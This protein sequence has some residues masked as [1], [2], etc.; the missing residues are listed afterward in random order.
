MS[1]ELG[2]EPAIESDGERH[3][4]FDH[5]RV[6][7]R[8]LGGTILTGFMGAALIGSAIFAALDH[9]SNF[10]EAPVPASPARK[11]VVEAGINPR[12]GDRLVKPVDIVAAKQTFRVPTPTKI[13]DKEAMR[14]HTFSHVE[15]TLLTATAG[16]ADDVPEFN[17]LKML[18]DARNTV[19]AAPEPLQDD[20]EISWANRDF[21][22]QNL[23]STIALSEDEVQAQVAEHVKS[24]LAAGSRPFSLPSQLLLTRTSR[25]NSIGAL[26]YANPNDGITRSPFSSIEVRMVPENVSVIPRSSLPTDASQMDERM[27]IMRHNE[28]FENML[29]TAGVARDTI[30]PIVAAFAAKPGD[31][32]VAEGRRIKLLFAD[33]D[34]P[35]Q[36]TVLARISVYADQTLETSIALKDDGGYV[37]LSAPATAAAAKPAA[38]S[39]DDGDDDTGGMRLYNSLYETGLKQDIPRPIIDDLVRV[40]A[41]DVDFQRGVSGGDSFEAFYDE[42]EDADGTKEL[43]HASIT[44]RG[45]TYKYYRFQTPDDGLVDFYDQNGRSTRKFLVRTPILNFKIT[46]GFGMRFHPILGYARPHLGVDFAAP[47]GTPIFAAG[48]GTIIKAGWNPA[49]GRR[50]EIQHA[51]GYVTTYN[52]M[53]GFARG[54]VDGARVKQG[55][56]I[57]YLGQTGLATGPHLHYEVLV[58][59]HFVDPMKVKLARTREFDGK[60][61]AQF[62]HERDRIDEL[63]SKAPNA[64]QVTARAN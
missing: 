46:S 42:G 18:A 22:P 52:H 56:T 61:L 32:V 4:F 3:T 17:P 59:G 29:M 36:A 63:L 10:A 31:P 51:N 16:F 8:W 1:V 37:R 24:S 30:P 50:I 64:P 40:F 21:S 6:S 39:D 53:S 33:S 62:T 57:G 54:A 11:E 25:A 48:N 23:T 60:M 20:A 13:G 43:L 38:K 49:Y 2:V 7:L 9:Q 19:D 35:G 5:R 28:S 12:K 14:I 27:V 58:N 26:A 44:A 41:N 15:T 45:E 55:Q 47:I 34:A